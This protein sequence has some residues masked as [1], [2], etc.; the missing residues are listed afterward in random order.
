MSNNKLQKEEL[1]KALNEPVLFVYETVVRQK[2]NWQ[3]FLFYLLVFFVLSRRV[4][5]IDLHGKPAVEEMTG[6]SKGYFYI[7]FL[8]II[9]ILLLYFEKKTGT[10]DKME[11]V[12]AGTPTRLIFFVK[13]NL[14]T[15][16]WNE[17]DDIEFITNDKMSQ[18]KLYFKNND[19]NNQERY[20][21]LP[22][23][24]N[25]N[26]IYQIIKNDILM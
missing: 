26:E 8:V 1:E 15:Y 10:F 20:L 13:D 25:P 23:P 21:F 9:I 18:I 2:F 17:F 5:D 14:K 3:F 7:I 4:M 19:V 16:N 12:V 6:L 11:Y 24:D 22:P